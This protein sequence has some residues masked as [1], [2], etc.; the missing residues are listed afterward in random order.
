MNEAE[1]SFL[2]SHL[3]VFFDEFYGMSNGQIRFIRNLFEIFHFLLIY[4]PGTTPVFKS[5]LAELEAGADWP[6]L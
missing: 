6:K 5:P 1:L 4:N 3:I 2:S